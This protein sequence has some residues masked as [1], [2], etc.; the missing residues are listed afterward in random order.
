[1]TFEELLARLDAKPVGSG[2][3]AYCPV[4]PDHRPSLSVNPGANGHTALKC[5]AGCAT[6]AVLAKANPT[7][8]DLFDNSANGNGSAPPGR[9]SGRRCLRIVTRTVRL[10]EN[11]R[12]KDPKTSRP[13]AIR[14][15]DRGIFVVFGAS[16][17]G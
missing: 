6:D 9:P 17:I 14:R 1:M 10:Y 16:C 5:H 15:S 13:V 11:V 3:M 12:L 7:Y 2:H 8:Q 4:H